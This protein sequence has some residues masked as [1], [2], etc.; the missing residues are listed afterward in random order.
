M[1][2]Y[3]RIRSRRAWASENLGNRALRLMS[4]SL[5]GQGQEDCKPLSFHKSGI[6][7]IFG[8][9]NSLVKHTKGRDRMERYRRIFGISEPI[10]ILRYRHPYSNKYRTYQRYHISTRICRYS[11]VYN[12]FWPQKGWL[13]TKIDLWLAKIGFLRGICTLFARLA[14]AS[15]SWP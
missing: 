5:E 12:W 11:I 13:V 4:L 14:S 1:Q 15:S 2:F 7:G 9:E 10:G 3:W 8:I 6:S